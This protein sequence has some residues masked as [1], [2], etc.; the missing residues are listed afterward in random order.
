MIL[1]S[2]FICFMSFISSAEAPGETFEVGLSEMTVDEHVDFRKFHSS[3][4]LKFNINGVSFEGLSDLPDDGLDG[5]TSA[6]NDE[7]KWSWE[8]DMRKILRDK[9]NMVLPAVNVMDDV[10]ESTLIINIKLTGTVGSARMLMEAL[11]H[12]ATEY[13]DMG[14]ECTLIDPS[15]GQKV[16]TLKDEFQYGVQREL[17]KFFSRDRSDKWSAAMNDWAGQIATFLAR[18]QGLENF[19]M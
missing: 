7:Q 11:K 9:I 15:S 6:T 14:I 2:S 18:K 8:Y 19:T 4:I 5:N 16:A 1:L 13:L 10:S 3:Y 17:P 12:G